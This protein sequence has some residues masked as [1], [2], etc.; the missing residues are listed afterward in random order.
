MSKRLSIPVFGVLMVAL[1]TMGVARAQE[2][3]THGEAESESQHE[4][5]RNHIAFFLGV[6]EGG[7]EEGKPHGAVSPEPSRSS[8]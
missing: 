4:F 3:A 1:A 6:T 8:W 7:E 5:H 2:E